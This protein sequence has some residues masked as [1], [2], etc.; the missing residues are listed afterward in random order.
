[1]LEADY[2]IDCNSNGYASFFLFAVAVTILIPIGVPVGAYL[3]MHKHKAAILAE[4]EDVLHEFDGLL[5]DFKPTFY[6]WEVI[7]LLRKLILAG[8]IMFFAP[9]SS[10]QVVAGL[11]LTFLFFAAHARAWPYKK[12]LHNRAKSVSELVVFVVL[13]GLL[14]EKPKPSA[15]LLQ[16]I[17]SGLTSFTSI[18]IIVMGVITL[19]VARETATP[20]LREIRG[21]GP[22]DEAVVEAKRGPEMR[23]EFANPLD[24]AA[25]SDA[26]TSKEKDHF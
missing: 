10:V 1:V 22:E 21:L 2:S 19:I 11:F 25:E 8:L 18:S 23:V 14:L 16:H 7:E 26:G 3:L 13:V 5:G 4:D 15:E 24:D 17:N 9:G 20:Y 12:D 6:Y